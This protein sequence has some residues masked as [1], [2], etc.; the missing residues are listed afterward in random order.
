MDV[1]G[2]PDFSGQ[3]CDGC[4]RHGE[5]RWHRAAIDVGK[6]DDDELPTED[7]V[8][9]QSQA[10]DGQHHAVLD[11]KSLHDD[12]TA[13]DARALRVDVPP[14]LTDV[15]A[16]ELTDRNKHRI[17]AVRE[18]YRAGLAGLVGEVP[19]VLHD[20]KGAIKGAWR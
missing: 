8:A 16:H 2:N 9:F 11:V 19:V 5:A 18:L 17:C 13:I 4:H 6:I 15:R 7:P 12:R 20:L 10:G 1:G 14:D 3:I